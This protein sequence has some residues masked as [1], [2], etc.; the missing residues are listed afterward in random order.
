MSSKP[1]ILTPES[2]ADLWKGKFHFKKEIEGPEFKVLESGLR[3]PQIG[4]LHSILAH[5]ECGDEDNGIIVMPTGTGKTETMLS[6]MIANQC[7]RI[8]VIVPSDALRAQIGDKSSTLGKLKE[9]GV[10][11]KD[12]IFPKVLKL[13]GDKQYEEWDKIIREHNV[14]VS[15]M[16]SMTNLDSRTKQLIQNQFDFLIVDEAHHSKASTWDIFITSFMR[17]KVLLFTA[18]PYRNDWKNLKVKFFLTILYGKHKRIAITNQLIPVLLLSII[19][20]MAT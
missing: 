14:V 3:P 16:A 15:T 9:I 19:E 18:T 11:D 4:A 12:T 1:H 5:L 17:N 8:L 2:I 20:Q 10:M 7:K 13:R 6:F